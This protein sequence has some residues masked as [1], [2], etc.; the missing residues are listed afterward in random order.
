MS[1]P[2]AHPARVDALRRVPLFADLDDETV[3]DLARS[4]TEV[5]VPRGHVLLERGQEGAGLFVVLG[6][7]AEVHV[8]ES[9]IEVG[10]GEILGEL[11]LLVPGLRHTARVQAGDGFRALAVRRDD[12]E[13][14]LGDHPQMAVAMLRVL[15]RR[16]AETLSFL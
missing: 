4:A 16:L 5:E 12:F 2:E 15:A 9:R 7:T 13:T 11:S 10:E 6:G 14:L 8:G 1:D 3:A